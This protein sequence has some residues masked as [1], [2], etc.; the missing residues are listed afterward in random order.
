MEAGA[1]QAV[2]AESASGPSSRRAGGSTEARIIFQPS[3]SRLTMAAGLSSAC[4][5]TQ[6][7]PAESGEERDVRLEVAPLDDRSAV[8]HPDVEHAERVE[9]ERRVLHI[10]VDVIDRCPG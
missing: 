2:S 6:P 4:F 5:T 1:A 10:D 7:G 3:P 9:M 8:R